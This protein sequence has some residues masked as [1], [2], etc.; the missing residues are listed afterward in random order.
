MEQD[1]R[2][3]LRPVNLM[4]LEHEGRPMIVLHDP[5]GM[6][7][8]DLVVTETAALILTRFDGEH[9]V[10]DIA[11][12]FSLL[13][14]RAIPGSQIMHLVAQLDERRFLDGPTFEAFYAG[15]VDAYRAAP[16][17]QT[18]PGTGLGAELH[19]L[20]T[21]LRQIV[22]EGRQDGPAGPPVGLIAPHLDLHRGRECYADAYGLLKRTNRAE[23][24]IILGTNHFGRSASVVATGKDFETPFG[25]AVNDREFLERLNRRC[26]TDLC[27]GEFDHRREHSIE[28]QV[29]F[30]QYI[31]YRRPFRIVPLLT[32]DPCGPTGTKPFNGD[33]VDLREFAEALGDEIRNDP[34][35]T[36]IIA[37]A[38]LSH[39]GRQFG[40]DG[41]LDDGFL[42][43][44][45]QRDR[46]ALGHAENRDAEAF[47]ACV[48]GEDNPTRICSA[49]C[50][51]AMLTALRRAY[52]GTPWSGHLLRYHQAVDASKYRGVTC[53]AMAFTLNGT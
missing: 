50:I 44:V 25:T 7:D 32:P 35:P 53:A 10:A 8:G 48:A 3:K 21:A 11:N 49:G 1:I 52:D 39:I 37:G 30:L 36:C 28:L 9:S 43:Q 27:R 23:R 14:G 46:E 47:R 40:D 17:R 19:Q 51:Y 16:T 45:E 34:V 20:P 33:G 5:T 38:D 18:L 29:L 4:P 22:A 42:K 41:D 2:P 26:N 12:E 31:L 15:L 13:A 6:A 24:F